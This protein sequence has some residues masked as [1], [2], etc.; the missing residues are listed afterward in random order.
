M[1]IFIVYNIYWNSILTAPIFSKRNDNM[2]D[3]LNDKD[4]KVKK[5]LSISVEPDDGGELIP[6]EDEEFERASAEKYRDMLLDDEERQRAEQ[7][8]LEQ[9]KREYEQKLRREKIA[10][11]KQKQ[12][13]DSEEDDELIE[14]EEEAPVQMSFPKKV[15]NFWYHYK[16]VLIVSVI[17]IGF[18]VY[19]IVDL[20]TKE[21]PDMIIACT[22]DNGLVY[23]GEALEKYFEEYCED[24]NGDGKVV[25]SVTFAPMNQDANINDIET[26]ST[27]LFAELSNA[28]CVLILTDDA[29]CYSLENVTTEDLSAISDSDMIDGKKLKMNSKLL[30]D[31]INWAQMPEDMYLVLRT[32]VQTLSDSVE[33]MAKSHDYAVE[34]L[35]RL[36]AD[37]ENYK[38]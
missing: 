22:V 6:E 21:I 20:A 12:G 10:M 38:G 32:P 33:D 29:S 36:I 17:V 23:R 30:R 24:I 8:E 28:N 1:F 2:S 19:M 13:I 11:M 18:A 26:N 5:K 14:E 25:V 27:K 3:T 35:K 16:W 9:Q 31:C 37:A 4:K 7:K 15:E 34:F